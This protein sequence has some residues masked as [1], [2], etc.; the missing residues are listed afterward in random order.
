[1][2][3]VNSGIGSGASTAGTKLRSGIGRGIGGGN[4]GMGQVAR[5]SSQYTGPGGVQSN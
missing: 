1:M 3:K 5:T 4:S 2:K